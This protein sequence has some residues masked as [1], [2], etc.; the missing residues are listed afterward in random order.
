MTPP[1]TTTTFLRHLRTP[2]RPLTLRRREASP[3]WADADLHA[4]FSTRDPELYALCALAD[5]VGPAQQA[6]VL[7]RL[8]GRSRQG[9]AVEVRD[10]LDRVA[11]R[12]LSA[13]DADAVVTVFLALRHARA[14]H[15]HVSRAVLR[16]LLNHPE[17]EE[18]ACRRRPA[19][20]DCLE[21][22]LGKDVARACARRLADP[23]HAGYVRRHLL[24]FARD[25]GRAAAA[26]AYLFGHGPC[27]EVRGVPAVADR[28]HP[29]VPERPKTITAT[30][31]GDVSA[32]LVHVYRGGANAQ[33]QGAL[34]RY[35]RDAAT[36]LPRFDGKVA[37]VLDLSASTLGYGEREFCCV[38][39]SQALRLVMEVCVADLRVI[40]VGGDGEPPRPDGATDL[41]TAV[42]D[43]LEGEPDVVAV[44]SDGYEN[45]AE[46]DLGRVAATLPRLGVT[47]PVVFCHSKFTAKDDLAL[48]RPAP[49]LPELEFWHEDDFADL[50]WSL[51]AQARTPRGEAFVR[52]DLRQRLLAGAK[53]GASA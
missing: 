26:V 37:L 29:V 24:R 8:L 50:L 49:G 13:L 30:N 53:E 20:R 15:R 42:L 4:E 17:L 45:V 16:Y 39:Q 31:R 18:L 7:F 19:L 36:R 44:V 51:F 5:H 10:V 41:A 43:A 9:L 48:R 27:P 46:G 23:A 33:L 12:L 6:R 47:T 14:N 22:A 28:V 34:E 1:L 11:G 2:A 3:R 52:A 21:H 35:V 32:T 38:A 25:P 40:P